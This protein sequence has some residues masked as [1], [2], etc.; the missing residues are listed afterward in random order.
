MLAYK[1]LVISLFERIKAGVLEVLR[2]PIVRICII[3]IGGF[4]KATIGF[5][6]QDEEGDETIAYIEN[7]LD[8]RKVIAV[9][10]S[11]TWGNPLLGN[12]FIIHSALRTLFRQLPITLFDSISQ[13]RIVV[14]S[15]GVTTLY[16][17]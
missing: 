12:S 11:Q 9:Y 16:E 15:I 5:A 1:P 2:T 6:I 14:T 3:P 17:V 8:K 13:Q 10:I 4:L 7:L